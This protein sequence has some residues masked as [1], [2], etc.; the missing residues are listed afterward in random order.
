[1]SGLGF[2]RAVKKEA[3]LKGEPA[4]GFTKPFLGFRDEPFVVS[5][6]RSHFCHSREGDTSEFEVGFK[7]R[8]QWVGGTVVNWA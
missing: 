5:E 2:P 8:A 3:D 4:P 6:F 1:M 7:I